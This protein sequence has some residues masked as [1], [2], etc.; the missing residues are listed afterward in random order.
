MVMG[1]FIN[2]IVSAFQFFAGK[3]CSGLCCPNVFRTHRR[4]RATKKQATPDSKIE[5]GVACFYVAL[6]LL[7]VGASHST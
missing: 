4:L 1:V 5:S 3:T 7:T 6:R 2:F